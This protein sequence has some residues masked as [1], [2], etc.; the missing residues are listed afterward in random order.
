MTTEKE[1]Y[2]EEEPILTPYDNLGNDIYHSCPDMADNYC[3]NDSCV[4]C[5]TSKLYK[6]G[7]RR[8]EDL[9][10]EFFDDIEIL[11]EKSRAEHLQFDLGYGYAIRLNLEELKKKWGVK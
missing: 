4:T 5:L 3:G 1:L 6:L 2:N 7:Y 9:A 8:K 11:L 10:K